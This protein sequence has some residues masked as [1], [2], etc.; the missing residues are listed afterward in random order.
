MKARKKPI[1]ID[2]WLW[3]EKN[4][5]YQELKRAGITAGCLVEGNSV[6]SL[7][8]KTLEGEMEARFGDYIIKGVIGEFYPVKPDVFHMTYEQL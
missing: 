8:I 4:A 2:A 6:T 1:I 3:D 7:K 5:T